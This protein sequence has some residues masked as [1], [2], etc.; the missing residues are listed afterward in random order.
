MTPWPTSQRPLLATLV[1]AGLVLAPM[2][3]RADRRSAL[4]VGENAGDEA[5]PPLRW[6]QTD[7]VRMRE[8]LVAAGGVAPRDALL[9]QGA[10]A[11]E[12]R[13]ALTALATRMRREGWSAADRLL[14]YVSAHASHG[15]L[16][17]RG[18]RLPVAELRRLLDAMPVGVTILVLDTCDSGAATRAKGLVPLAGPV[19]AIDR[20]SLNG[21]VVMA[22]ARA[23]EPAFESD[24]LGGSLFTH[25]LAAGLRGAADA[26]KDGR[27]TLHEAYGYAWSRTVDGSV[28]LQ[29][30]RQSPVFDFDLAGEGELVL[31]EPRLGR[32]RLELALPE[33]G[34]WVVTSADAGSLA[35]R[36][37]KGEGPVLFALEPG[38]YRVRCRRGD[39]QLEGLVTIAAGTTTVRRADL[40]RWAL[41]PGG[42]KGTGAEL[43]LG[44]GAAVGTGAV[45]GLGPLF[46]GTL[47]A[48][49]L[50]DVPFSNP[51]PLFLARVGHRF[52][53]ALAEPMT[54]H[55]TELAAGGG[56]ALRT[57]P[58]WLA[59]TLTGGAT[60]VAQS[61]AFGTRLGVQPRVEAG[62]AA[63]WP[64]GASLTLEAAVGAGVLL[65]RTEAALRP[66]AAGVATLG[67]GYRP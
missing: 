44:I 64:L 4:L 20:P 10:S 45:A 63:W 3:A 61:G 32:S 59:L 12:L 57:G 49:W 7:A 18:S 66:T 51:R 35:V 50:A 48:R 22:A 60:V 40:D 36:F 33:P 39:H 24:S 31:S 19:S 38:V 25:H 11:A 43:R 52:G 65:V 16:R 41:V 67:L 34:E 56:F 28:G 62:L 55:E 54:E 6:A 15:E 29:S 47:E 30:G 14:V 8:V 27:V 58:L 23:G 1:L 53:D 37:V 13:E 21:R 2:P 17:L 5:D 26:S 42:R 46:G 9:L